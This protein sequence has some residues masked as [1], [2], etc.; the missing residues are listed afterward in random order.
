VRQ[1]ILGWCSSRRFASGC[2]LRA[3][4]PG[5]ALAGCGAGHRQERVP[6]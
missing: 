3:R 5:W 2:E 4:A 6:R 1:T